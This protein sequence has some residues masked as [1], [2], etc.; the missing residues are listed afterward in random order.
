MIN[1][2]YTEHDGGAS[3]LASVR[4]LQRMRRIATALRAWAEG[5]IAES[6]D[7]ELSLRLDALV[8]AEE[9][10]GEWVAE[11]KRLEAEAA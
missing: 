1:R 9:R 8:V 5:R 10:M 2:I 6:F 4:D 11:R 3:R 7:P